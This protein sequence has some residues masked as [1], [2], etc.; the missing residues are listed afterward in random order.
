[1]GDTE[2]VNKELAALSRNPSLIE[3]QPKSV[4]EWNDMVNPKV[5]SVPMAVQLE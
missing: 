4:M 1:M 5:D 2:Y 3:V